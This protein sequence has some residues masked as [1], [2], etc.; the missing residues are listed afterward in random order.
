VNTIA[1]ATV[2]Y[3]ERKGWPLAGVDVTL[4]YVVRTRTPGG[5]TG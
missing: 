5:S 3:A 2:M 4:T 1:T